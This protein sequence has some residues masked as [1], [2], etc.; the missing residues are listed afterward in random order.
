MNPFIQYGE[1]G[2]G[3]G[4]ISRGA[5]IQINIFVKRQLDLYLGSFKPGGKRLIWGFMICLVTQANY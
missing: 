1:G 2:G 3:G 5:Y 4:L